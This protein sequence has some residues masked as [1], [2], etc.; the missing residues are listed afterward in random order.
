MSQP[1][2]VA[3]TDD[4]IHDLNELIIDEEL[5][6]RFKQKDKP[7]NNTIIITCGNCK[8][9]KCEM[10]YASGNTWCPRCK[11]FNCDA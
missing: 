9:D 8:F 4:E 5:K 6:K 11:A 7:L 10:Y 3:L 1:Y 2:P